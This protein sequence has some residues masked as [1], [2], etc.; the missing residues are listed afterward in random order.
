MGPNNGNSSVSTSGKESSNRCSPA[1]VK[2]CL[3]TFLAHLFSHI[4]LCILVVGYAIVGA[5][6]FERL[7][8]DF[9]IKQRDI[10]R[11]FFGEIRKQYVSELWNIT[12]KYIYIKN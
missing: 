9:E 2:N 4:G 1:R 8:S 3:R 12:G 11:K 7:E 10:K 6:I 5:A